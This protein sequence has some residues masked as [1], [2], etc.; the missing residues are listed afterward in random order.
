MFT[1]TNFQPTE[2]KSTNTNIII[3]TYKVIRI[4]LLH[5]LLFHPNGGGG[6]GIA[7][8][9]AAVVAA[10]VAAVVAAVL[11]L[12][13]LLM[14]LLLLLLLWLLLWLL[15]LLWLW[16]WLWL[17]LLL[18]RLLLLL[19][20]LPTSS[21]AAAAAFFAARTVP[22]D[23]AGLAA[24]MVSTSAIHHLQHALSHI[25]AA[26]YWR[27]AATTIAAATAIAAAADNVLD[28]S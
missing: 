12:L 18:L 21:F 20:L 2:K 19:P 7:A 11:L 26:N 3:H 13:L 1:I 22:L 10:A 24:T 17:L 16:L 8:V 15:L 28:T 5:Y 9:V 14:L 4:L 25:L 27:L 6:S 23:V